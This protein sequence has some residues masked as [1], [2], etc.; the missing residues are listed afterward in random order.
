M[1]GAGGLTHPAMATHKK[2]T[3]STGLGSPLWE[4]GEHSEFIPSG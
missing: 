2:G 3:R 1:K 4:Y